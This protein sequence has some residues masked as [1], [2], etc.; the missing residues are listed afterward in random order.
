MVKFSG[1]TRAGA[2]ILGIGLS[3]ENCRRLLEGHPIRFAAAEMIP[4]LALT[5]VEVVIVGGEDEAAIVR[6][7]TESALDHGVEVKG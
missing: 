4:G 5:P 3:R 7:I 1:K 2:D 6:E